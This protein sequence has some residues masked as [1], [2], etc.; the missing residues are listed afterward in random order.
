MTQFH[1][2]LDAHLEIRD[3]V[4]EHREDLRFLVQ[5]NNGNVLAHDCPSLLGQGGALGH[6]GFDRDLVAQRFQLDAASV[7][8]AWSPATRGVLLASPS[9]PT[10]TS[11]APEEMARIAEVV[12]GRGG[13]LLVDEIYLG[14]SFEDRFDHSALALGEDLVVI[15]SFSK[16]F[17][18]TGWRL[19]WL[20]LPPAL[21]APVERLAQNLYI[22]P[23]ALA[24]HAALA[25]FTPEALAESE[26][27]RA[28]FRQ[29]RDLVVPGLRA[30]G[31]EVPVLPDG[32]FYAWADCTRH[33]RAGRETS[34]AFCFEMM[35]RAQVAL[36][37]GRDFGP[38]AAERC[39]RLSFANSRPALELALQRLQQAL[40][41]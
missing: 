28:E 40:A 41:S 16:T 15:N 12:R 26:A 25:C 4:V 13:A 9:N 20:V 7:A 30:M 21:V 22:C 18:M 37:P 24:Q 5:R 8:A 14:L 32:A 19:G 33:L 17:C 1:V 27:R 31:L 11:I 23:P 38:A 34:W 36:T 29:R 35:H 10:G 2:F 3:A 6:V 39:F